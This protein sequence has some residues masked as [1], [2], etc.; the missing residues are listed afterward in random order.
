MIKDSPVVLTIEET[1]ETL[2]T[3]TDTVYVLVQDPNF[4]AVKI[5]GKWKI[6]YSRLLVWL[7]QQ[8]DDKK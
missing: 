5:G 3:S 2:K 4:P 7:E 6:V 8:C 1:S